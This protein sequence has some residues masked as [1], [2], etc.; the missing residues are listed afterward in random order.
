LEGWAEEVDTGKE[1]RFRSNDE[2]LKFLGERFD[3]V[4]ALEP[5]GGK[6]PSTG[7]GDEDET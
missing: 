1:L 4:L 3:A 2:L 6:T 5:D 7:L